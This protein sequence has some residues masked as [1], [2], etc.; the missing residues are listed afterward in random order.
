VLE[1]VHPYKL[2]DRLQLS[3]SYY[4]RRRQHL[5][6]NTSEVREEPDTV[7]FAGRK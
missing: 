3:L 4:T 7:D 5:E 1:E 2:A 6:E